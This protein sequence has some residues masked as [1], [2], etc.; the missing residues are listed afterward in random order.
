VRQPFHVTMAACFENFAKVFCGLAGR[1]RSRHADA[2]KA[3]LARLKR[4][5]R[6][7]VSRR[8]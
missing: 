6:F 8:F 3:E 2:V 1:I 4:Q 7:Q 5:R